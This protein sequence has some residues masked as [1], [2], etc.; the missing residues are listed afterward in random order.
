MKFVK[1]FL[2]AYKTMVE[3]GKGVLGKTE[4]RKAPERYQIRKILIDP[5]G[6]VLLIEKGR[7]GL[8]RGVALTEW[9]ELARTDTPFPGYIVT[10]TETLVPLPSILYLSEEFILNYTTL[11]GSVGE[12]VVRRFLEYAEKANPPKE[13]PLS[14]FFKEEIPR[15]EAIS[16]GE[17]ISSVDREELGTLIVTVALTSK[18][19]E[20]LKSYRKVP[21]AKA[22]SE[23]LRGRNWL[24]V[25]KE[26]KL[27][28][29]LPKS[30]LGK[31]VR[32]KV[33]GETV[34][35]GPARAVL[36]LENMPEG[37]D[38]TPLE[39]DLEVEYV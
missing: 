13:G 14:E 33:S 36:V 5:P 30:A 37:V 2:S 16:L 24:G 19:I 20:I 34:Y 25:L 39:R 15:L 18:V 38:Y 1:E 6:Y 17:I 23:Y 3:E 8:W 21:S 10:K 9:V 22:P 11:V 35:E 7:D 12:D 29:Y 31:N 26:G 28:L 27:R 4:E 32:V